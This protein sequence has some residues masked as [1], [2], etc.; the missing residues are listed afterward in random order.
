MNYELSQTNSKMENFVRKEDSLP[1][2]LEETLMKE[3]FSG[4]WNSSQLRNVQAFIDNIREEF[5]SKVEN[6]IFFD[7]GSDGRILHFFY[8]E[9]GCRE[10]M[11]LTPTFELEIVINLKSIHQKKMTELFEKR[12]IAIKLPEK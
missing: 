4:K 12:G 1:A 11:W 6:C 10:Y 5:N 2:L 7:F 9:L 3:L 8:D